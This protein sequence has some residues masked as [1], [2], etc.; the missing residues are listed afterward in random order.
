[1]VTDLLM[2]FTIR[3][4]MDSDWIMDRYFEEKGLLNCMGL[5]LLHMATTVKDCNFK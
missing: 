5:Y 1:M 2:A 4:H 3:D